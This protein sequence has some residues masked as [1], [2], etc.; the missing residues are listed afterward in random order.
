M[1]EREG[2]YPPKF[3]V[4]AHP[5]PDAQPSKVRFNFSGGE[6]RMAM[7]ILLLTEGLEAVLCAKEC[8]YSQWLLQSINFI[9]SY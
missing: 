3:T 2:M 9:N 8:Y 5:L 1:E 7:D 6:K 4:R